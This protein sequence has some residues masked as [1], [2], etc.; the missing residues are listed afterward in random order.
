[1]KRLI[2]GVAA[3]VLSVLGTNVMAQ[4][5][6]E[7]NYDAVCAQTACRDGGYTVLIVTGSDENDAV[8]GEGVS[9]PHSPYVME[10]G[11]LLIL[12]GET[13]VYSL[14][15]E[16]ITIKATF[17]G[18]Y[19]PDHPHVQ[20][21]NFRQDWTNPADDGLKPLELDYKGHPVLGPNQLMISYG[22]MAPSEGKPDVFMELWHNFPGMIKPKLFMQV[23]AEDGPRFVYT[24][25]CPILTGISSYEHWPHQIGAMIVESLTLKPGNN[26]I[27]CE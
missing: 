15:A 11:A 19:Y 1:M 9:I 26:E 3:L 17:L 25:S 27:V 16:G 7:P 20:P 14:T 13:I 12:P 22:Q 24:S 21:E 2:C 4:A 23:F 8:M 18:R 6:T 5:A 10:D